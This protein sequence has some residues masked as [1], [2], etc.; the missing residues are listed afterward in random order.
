MVKNMVQIRPKIWLHPQCLAATLL[1]LPGQ[2]YIV[3]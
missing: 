3:T 1:T 2:S